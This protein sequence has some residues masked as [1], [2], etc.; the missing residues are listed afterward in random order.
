MPSQLRLSRGGCVVHFDH[1]FLAW[2]G[3]VEPHEEEIAHVQE[4]VDFSPDINDARTLRTPPTS[5]CSAYGRETTCTAAKC[6][7]AVIDPISLTIS[8]RKPTVTVTQLPVRGGSGP[9]M[10]VCFVYAMEKK[11]ELL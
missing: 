9:T 4:G 3:M 8:T 6:K 7:P 10:K 11:N 5:S 2:R 1:A